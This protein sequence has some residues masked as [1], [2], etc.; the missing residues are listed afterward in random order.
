MFSY[1]EAQCFLFCSHFRSIPAKPPR[2]GTFVSDPTHN[3]SD[4][5]HRLPF[6]SPRIS[7]PV[8]AMLCI[9][10]ANGIMQNSNLIPVRD[11][12]H[13]SAANCCLL[14]TLS[15]VLHNYIYIFLPAIFFHYGEI[16]GVARR[17][18]YGNVSSLWY[19]NILQF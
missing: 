1:Q 10:T 12:L 11:F 19:K 6:S 15:S 3:L 2:L 8:D 13:S 18:L 5:A 7:F 4:G 9:P 16:I 14:Q 17:Y